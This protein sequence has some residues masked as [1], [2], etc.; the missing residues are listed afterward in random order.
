M[1]RDILR[2]D[3]VVIPVSKYLNRVRR[4]LVPTLG[5]HC[6]RVLLCD[7]CVFWVIKMNYLIG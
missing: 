4:F 5:F 2:L 3:L 1:V 7:F 6:S